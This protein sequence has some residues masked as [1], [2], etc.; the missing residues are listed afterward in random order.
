MSIPAI[1]V[2]HF[3]SALEL[4]TDGM[5][6]ELFNKEEMEELLGLVCLKSS[7]MICLDKL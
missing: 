1:I 7:H 2:F 4:M 6:H 3:D 5:D